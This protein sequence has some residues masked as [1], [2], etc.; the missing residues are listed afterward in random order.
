MGD[1]LQK[2]ETALKKEDRVAALEALLAGWRRCR[3]PE[4]EAVIDVVSHDAM[5]SFPPI[6][7]W[8]GREHARNAGELELLVPALWSNPR[9]AIPVRLRALLEWGDDP[10]LGRAML[11]MI[12]TPPVTTTASFSMWSHL[13]DVLPRFVDTR[14]GKQLLARAKREGGDSLFWPKLTAW[15][16]AV[17]PKL[18][19][20]AGLSAT[21]AK[22]V[23]KLIKLAEALAEGDPSEAIT[24]PDGRTAIRR[25]VTR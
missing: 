8:T 16:G 9:S 6:E 2:A 4:L 22:Q 3:A 19:P 17:R 12:D 10:R 1:A 7:D 24:E 21:H 23:S 11:T 14:A 5:R 13:F 18:Q 15:I 25:A 20:P